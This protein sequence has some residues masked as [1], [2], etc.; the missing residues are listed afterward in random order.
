MKS[1]S[2][3]MKYFEG[4]DCQKTFFYN[5]YILAINYFSL[6]HLYAIICLTIFHFA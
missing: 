2:L 4:G 1:K 5:Q 3:L 6:L